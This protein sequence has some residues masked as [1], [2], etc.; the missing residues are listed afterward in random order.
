MRENTNKRKF[1]YRLF[2]QYLSA[3]SLNAEK[4]GPEKLRIRMFHAVTNK[5][6]S[7]YSTDHGSTSSAT[8]RDRGVNYPSSFTICKQ[9]DLDSYKNRKVLAN[10]NTDSK[11]HTHVFNTVFTI[12]NFRSV[13]L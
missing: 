2:S 13:A 8:H 1:G 3:F 5:Q 6:V 4:H 10:L 9:V 11:A 7:R 12:T